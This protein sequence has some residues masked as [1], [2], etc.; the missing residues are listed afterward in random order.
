MERL[1]DEECSAANR[2][3]PQSTAKAWAEKVTE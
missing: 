3:D 2:I 1:I